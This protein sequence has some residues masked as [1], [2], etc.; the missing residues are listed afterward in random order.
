MQDLIMQGT[1]FIKALIP[2]RTEIIVGTGVSI[3]GT[4]INH[5]LGGY[6]ELLEYWII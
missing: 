6:D 2:V 4:V 5:V 1:E 3:M